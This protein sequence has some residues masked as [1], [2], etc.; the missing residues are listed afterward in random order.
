M[1]FVIRFKCFNHPVSWKR[2]YQH[3][4]DAFYRYRKSSDNP[5]CHGEWYSQTFPHP[6]HAKFPPLCIQEAC[7]TITSDES[8]W[9]IADTAM[10]ESTDRAQFILIN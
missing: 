4:I 2:Q 10:V 5:I 1:N 6:S 9:E 7:W 3:L 8:F